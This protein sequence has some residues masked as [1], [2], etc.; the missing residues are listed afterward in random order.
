MGDVAGAISLL[1]LFEGN[2][3]GFALILGGVLLLSSFVKIVTVLG[4]VRVGLGVGSFPSA[5]V[6]GGLAIALSIITMM[7]TLLAVS[8][9]MKSLAGASGKLAPS[10]RTEALGRAASKWQDFLAQH[11]EEKDVAR[12]S[13]LQKEILK[14]EQQV[15]DE[16]AGFGVYASAFLVTELREAFATGLTL[17]LPFLVVD[18][19]IA[20]ILLAL[21]LVQLAPVLVALPFKLLLFVMVDGWG[22]ITENLIRSYL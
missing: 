1:E 11:A 2:L 22:L 18:L 12:F 5:F 10:E 17:F 3:L 14:E 19:V 21:G 4:L 8:Q 13:A 20:Q 15:S 16:S 6:T 7:P 9:E